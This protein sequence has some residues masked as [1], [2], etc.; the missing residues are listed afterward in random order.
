MIDQI[1]ECTEGIECDLMD[2]EENWTPCDA[3]DESSCGLE[4]APEGWVP[5]GPPND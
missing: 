1:W 4:G 2:T 3:V 5:P